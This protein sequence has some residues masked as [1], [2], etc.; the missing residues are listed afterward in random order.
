MKLTALFSP[1]HRWSGVAF[2]HCRVLL[3]Q[4]SFARRPD[5][6]ARLHR[7]A[8]DDAPGA[9]GFR[10]TLLT[11]PLYALVALRQLLIYFWR[12]G[13]YVRAQDGISSVRQLRDLWHCVWRHNH[14]ARHYYWRKLYRHPDRA[15][16]LLN[17]EHRQLTT[18]LRHLNR[19][20]PIGE[21]T[22]KFT[23][24]RHC[25]QHNLP[26]PAAVAAWT[27]TGVRR[28]PPPVAVADDLF[29]KPTQE[30]GSTGAQVLPYDPASRTHRLAGRDFAWSQLMS[31]LGRRARDEKRGLIIQRRLHNAPRQAV[32]GDFDVCNLRLVTGCMPGGTP[33]LLGS[34]IRLPSRFTTAG[35]GRHVLFASVDIRTG[36]MRTGRFREITRGEF[37]LH[38]ES[39]APIE[40]RIIPGWDDLCA[41]ALRAHR[42]FPWLPFV[43]WDVVDTDQGIM[44]LEANAFWGGDALQPH[45]A[46]P[47]GLTRFP[48]IYL[49]WFDRLH[50][51][52]G[53]T[54]LP[55]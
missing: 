18:L 26:T 14:S 40:G 19:H 48:E 42:S 41:L 24:Y 39:G 17:L 9:A 49:A 3:P 29:L 55:S 36:R 11:R 27:D 16:W 13:S 50:G 30:Y 10:R 8:L 53:S 6:L 28:T 54:P 31:R 38:P 23:F 4:F 15:T 12:Y 32:Y 45:D 5:D 46:V 7:L 1:A 34:F 47:L 2:D 22:D 35:A 43:G 20:L 44:L 25:R 37:P 21:A 51:P 52:D 33:E